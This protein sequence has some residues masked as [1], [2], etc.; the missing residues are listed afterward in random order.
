MGVI[1][2]FRDN[3]EE[4]TCPESMLTTKLIHPIS[5]LAN[6]LLLVLEKGNMIWIK[7]NIEKY[8][9]PINPLP[10]PLWFLDMLK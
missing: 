2:H 7:C 10:P 4:D 1:S 3:N 6:L 8:T 5:F 9:N